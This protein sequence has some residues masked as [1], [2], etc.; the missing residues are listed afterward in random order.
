MSQPTT[1]LGQY[2]D[3]ERTTVQALRTGSPGFLSDPEDQAVANS[4][5]LRLWGGLFHAAFCHGAPVAY[6]VWNLHV[7]GP[8]VN[9]NELVPHTSKRHTTQCRFSLY[10]QFVES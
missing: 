4:G 6:K 7:R 9:S 2:S 5:I 10:F 3:L 1:D 8:L